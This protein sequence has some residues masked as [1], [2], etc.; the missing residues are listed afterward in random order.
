MH[1]ADKRLNSSTSPSWNRNRTMARSSVAAM[2]VLLHFVPPVGCSD[3]GAER[4]DVLDIRRGDSRTGSGAF[5]PPMI[6]RSRPWQS[7]R[8]RIGACRLRWGVAESSMGDTGRRW[9]PSR[10]WSPLGSASS[11]SRQVYTLEPFRG[12]EHG[13]GKRTKVWV[14]GRP[15]RSSPPVPSGRSCT[16]WARAPPP[17]RRSHRSARSR[18]AFRHRR[19]G[20]RVDLGDLGRR[21]RHLLAS[22]TAPDD[23][24][25][26]GRETACRAPERRCRSSLVMLARGGAVV[27]ATFHRLLRTGKQWAGRHT[28]KGAGMSTLTYRDNPEMRQRDLAGYQVEAT[29][30]KIDASDRGY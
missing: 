26:T 3:P 20:G 30:G 8:D 10:A 22:T 1:C 19:R 16:T 29:D 21:A 28:S 5:P 15:T 7:E 14:E 25:L 2:L 9:R 4:V 18:A 27:S 6:V 17:T 11:A 12:A 24:R 23:A 13:D